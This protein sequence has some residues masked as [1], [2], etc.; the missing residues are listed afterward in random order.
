[1]LFQ[2]LRH[3]AALTLM[4][5]VAAAAL[6]ALPAAAE[7]A[8]SSYNIPA[9][10]LGAALREFARQSNKQILFSTD[11]V[12]GKI[13]HGLSGTLT[14]DAA[15]NQLL[16]GTGLV[17]SKSADGT[18]L[19]GRPE[20]KRSSPNPSSSSALI[21]ATA[22]PPESSPLGGSNPPERAASLEDI[23]VTAQRRAEG[24]E[25]VPISITALSQ[26]TM[27]DLHVQSFG[28][29]ASIVPGL[30]INAPAPVEQGSSEVAIRGI[31]SGGNAPTTAI[32]ID[33]TP[34][35]VR[36]LSGAG[37]SGSFHPDIFDLDR[38]EVLRGPQ[39]TLFGSSAMGGAI[40]FI[41]P[42]PSLDE[43]SGYAKSEFGYTDRGDPSYSVGVA[44]GA[45][46]VQ[47]MAGFRMS[48]WYHY[49]GGFIDA[50]DPFTGQIVR[51]NT[52]SSDAYTLR[53][54]VMLAPTEGL[55]ITPAVFIQHQHSNAPAEYWNTL[56]PDPQPGAHTTGALLPQPLWDD[57]TVPSL[58][59]KYEFLGMALQSD[60]SYLDRW[61]DNFDDTS[62]FLEALFDGDQPLDPGISRS[63]ASESEQKGGTKAW[64]QEFRLTSPDTG[65]W[66]HWIV[67]AY[68]R[69]AQETL[70]QLITPD[71]SPITLAVY[72]QTSE[73]Y[74]GVPN[75]NFNGQVL[76]SY[77]WF[78]TVDEQRALFGETS[79][80][81]TSHLKATAGVR[82]EHSAVVQQ[83]EVV[84]GPLNGTAYSRQVVPDQVQNPITPRFALTYQYT[85]QDMVYASASKGYRAGG[86]NSATSFGNSLCDPSLKAIGLT[87]VPASFNSD[88]LWS[89][90]LGAKDAFFGGR[91][92]MQTSVF[93]IN[94]TNI[95]SQIYLPSCS[96]NFTTNQGKAISQGFDLQIEAV[97]MDGLK[98]G[99]NV[100]YTD[101]YYPKAAYGAPVDGVAPLLNAAGD[102]L[103][104]VLPW[105]ASAHAEYSW[106]VGSWWSDA[107]PY[108]RADY[109]WL[110]SAP[111]GDPSVANYDPGVG[112][113][114][115]QSY[116][117]L[118]L[119]IGV[120]R[121]GLDISGY[122]NNATNSDPRL[123]YAH[124]LPGDPLY[125]ATALRPLTFGVTALYRQ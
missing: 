119:R 84:A 124:Y 33:E 112:P 47:G 26:K 101:A 70:S 51:R 7:E 89:Y 13:T 116:G 40:R 88:S 90:E 8:A 81:I 98:L 87:S 75:Y 94:W 27:D 64:Q 114:P 115:N 96:E 109:R 45:P 105:T 66:L 97:P 61:Y 68:F 67:G 86:G 56:I 9:Q 83:E 104:Q 49:D 2:R 82:I 17:A 80:D 95:Q 110:D 106:D 92:A 123:S 28:D 120:V 91:L 39:G 102:K 71:L 121:R 34:V 69:H 65:F 63:F 59:I 36:E 35:S 60:T 93:Y 58:A 42:Q 14:V 122:V 4:A 1:M 53:P 38:V 10:E 48:G 77:T 72:G 5:G 99:A 57:V 29:L 21:G 85:E 44:Y 43:S 11:V 25:K 46:I 74:F 22:D 103:L 6:I 18:I 73:Q 107:R 118:N 37:P 79:F 24:V 78:R 52:N 19:I 117:I 108:V 100:G 62:R 12:A 54:A 111:K 125:Y 76:N 30:V 3:M 113:Y 50:E 55:T 23:V 31:F 32:Y 20:P 15:L 41:T 16:A